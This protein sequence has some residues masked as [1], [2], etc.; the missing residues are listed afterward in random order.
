MQLQ[1][2][3]KCMGGRD[4]TAMVDAYVGSWFHCTPIH[5]L[6][7]LY[8]K[9]SFHGTYRWIGRNTPSVTSWFWEKKRCRFKGAYCNMNSVSDFCFVLATA[10]SFLTNWLLGFFSQSRAIFR[11]IDHRN[12]K[13]EENLTEASRIGTNH[14]WII[15]RRGSKVLL[16]AATVA[17][18]L[19]SKANR[20]CR[21]RVVYA[22]RWRL[23]G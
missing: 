13:I 14:E 19:L 11:K 7:E 5:Y 17:K 6:Y 3:C 22:G 1:C 15:R 8:M 9:N 21:Q 2:W 10:W 20:I 18:N 16:G 23:D 4:W 12:Q